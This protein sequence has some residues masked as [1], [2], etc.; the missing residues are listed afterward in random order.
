[1]SNLKNLYLMMFC[2]LAIPLSTCLATEQ[3]LDFA[4]PESLDIKV[5]HTAY[6]L[7]E[8]TVYKTGY[9]IKH[10]KHPLIRSLTETQNGNMAIALIGKINFKTLSRPKT[11]PH[12]LAIASTPYKITDISFFALKDSN[13]MMNA[14]NWRTKYQIGVVR[15]PHTHDVSMFT[16]EDNINY[17][18]Y[19]NSLSA[20]K[21]L[22]KQRVELVIS[23]ELDYLS[24]KSI[25][26]FQDNIKA[27]TRIGTVGIYPVFSYQ[28]FGEKEAK[29][30]AQRYDNERAKLTMSELKECE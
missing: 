4:V 27:I 10:V 12:E 18:F 23:S 2:S 29:E 24:A 13:I 8:K 15:S 28:Y 5:D 6:C 11:I 30:L 3:V 16:A 22:L 25:L 26:N 21:G 19:I 9:K 20:F 14:A 7:F 17:H 1:M